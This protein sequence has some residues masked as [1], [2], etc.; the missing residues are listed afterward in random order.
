MATSDWIE[1]A[2][3][4]TLPAAV[5]PVAAG[6]AIAIGQDGASLPR[7]VLAAIVALAIQVGVNYS[8]DY[9]DGIRGTD[10]V[11]TGPPRLTGGGK[12]APQTVKLAAFASYGVGC[13]VGL[14]LVAMTGQWWL[15]GVGAACVIAAWFYTG[16]KHP[17]GYMGLGEFFVFIFFGLVATAGT[18]YTQILHVPW[19]GWLV[20]SAIGLI[21][22]ALLMANNIRDIPTDASVGKRTLAVRLGDR[23]ARASY[24]AMVALPICALAALWGDLGALTLLAAIPPTLIAVPAIRLVLSDAKGFALIAA[25]KRT[26]FIELAYGVALLVAYAIASA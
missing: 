1:G 22:C 13:L 9:S 17:Y 21:A 12:A 14:V 15:I 16:G 19:Q 7:A 10:D 5:S 20:A 23:P 4:R 3:P 24:A 6:T 25:L 26:G 18:T 8:N 11:R 2:R